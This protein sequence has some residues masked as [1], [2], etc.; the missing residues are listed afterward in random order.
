MRWD[1]YLCQKLELLK[2]YIAQVTLITSE[3]AA[4]LVNNH[5]RDYIYGEK[6]KDKAKWIKDRKKRRWQGTSEMWK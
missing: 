5:S 2:R 1:L 6:V 4:N 3:Q